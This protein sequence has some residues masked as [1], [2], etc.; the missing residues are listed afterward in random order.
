[1]SKQFWGVIVIVIL[2]FAGIFALSG[3]TSTNSGKAGTVTQHVEGQGQAG[4]TL[5]EYGDYQCPFCGQ[6]F[7]IVKQVQQEFNQQIFFQF[8]NFPL[9]SL[10]QNAFAAAR[11]AEAAALQGKFWEMHD[12]LYETQSQWSGAGDAVP[13]FNQ[14]AT[15]LGLNPT[16]FKA[17]Y[18]SGKVNNLI[19]ADTAE[20]TKLNVQGTPTFFLDGKQIQVGQGVSAFEKL[21]NAEIA[22]KAGKSSSAPTSAG[23]TSQTAAPAKQ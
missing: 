20:G 17:D 12:A 22:K 14:L 11:A 18:A 9:V 8:R 4:V 7:P 10:H 5:V 23:S 2:I 1:M 19:N 16:Q 21:I 15:Q 3:K 6:Y 13:Y